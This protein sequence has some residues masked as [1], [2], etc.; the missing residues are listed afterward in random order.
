MSLFDGNRNT[1]EER[2]YQ[3]LIALLDDKVRNSSIKSNYP[4]ATSSMLTFII[5]LCILFGIGF[6]LFYY[7]F[8]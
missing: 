8:L 5:I 4:D 3:Q 6:G 1:T 7:Y 2:L